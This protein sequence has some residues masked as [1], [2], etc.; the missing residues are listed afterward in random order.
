VRI[1]HER[2][3]VSAEPD[4]Q[5]ES[6][7]QPSVVLEVA[8]AAEGIVQVAHAHRVMCPGDLVNHFCPD[9]IPGCSAIRTA[10]F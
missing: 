7:L 5:E 3:F 4:L 10:P 9:L 2:S 6:I 1:K 8:V